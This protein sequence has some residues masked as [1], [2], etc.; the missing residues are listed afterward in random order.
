MKKKNVFGQKVGKK[1][2]NRGLQLRAYGSYLYCK[3]NPILDI[4]IQFWL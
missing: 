4:S 1:Y 3:W 2:T